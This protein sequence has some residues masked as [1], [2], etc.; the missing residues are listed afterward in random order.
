MKPHVELARRKSKIRSKASLYTET[1]KTIKSLIITLTAMILVLLVSSFIINNNNSQRGYT[2]EQQK[3]KNED[4][5]LINESLTTKIT[6][7]TSFNEINKSEPFGNMEPE[8]NKT[9]VTK[10]DLSLK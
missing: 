8:T 1:R 2:L 4:L 10:E 5:K 7:S 6:K 3:L 9:Y